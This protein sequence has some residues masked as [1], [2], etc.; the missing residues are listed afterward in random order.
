MITGKCNVYL[1]RKTQVVSEYKPGALIETRKTKYGIT[2]T[3]T[4]SRWI[5]D[6]REKANVL[7][8]SSFTCPA[9]L[10]H[11]AARF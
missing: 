8:N 3:M 5:Q 11:P 1:T 10:P 7:N 2:A 9:R 6:T 4:I